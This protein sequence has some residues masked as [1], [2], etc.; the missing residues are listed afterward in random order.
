MPCAARLRKFIFAFCPTGGGV[1]IR[2][3]EGERGNIVIFIAF[4][5]QPVSTYHDLKIMIC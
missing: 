4:K 3:A 2:I 5:Q 1:D